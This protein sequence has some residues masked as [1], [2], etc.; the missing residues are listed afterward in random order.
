M[1]LPLWTR[2]FLMLLKTEISLTFCHLSYVFKIYFFKCMQHFR[3]PT[4]GDISL[5]ACWKWHCWLLLG[6]ST[7]ITV[8]A[9]ANKLTFIVPPNFVFTTDYIFL[10]LSPFHFLAWSSFSLF[11]I[12]N[13]ITTTII[14]YWLRNSTL[15]FRFAAGFACELLPSPFRNL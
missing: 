11:L 4:P 12:S 7:R 8:T 10:P 14:T 5:C 2:T 3:C 1:C 15:L 9:I 6:E 13:P